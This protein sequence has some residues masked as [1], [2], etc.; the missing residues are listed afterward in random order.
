MKDDGTIEDFK[1]NK[2]DLLSLMGNRGKDVE[3]YIKANRLDF[4]DKY[5]L[6]KIVSYYNSLMGT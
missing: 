2:N 1:G 3:K 5:D 4:D 6:A